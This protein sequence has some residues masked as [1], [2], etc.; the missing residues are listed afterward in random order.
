MAWTLRYNDALQS[1]EVTF[2][3]HVGGPEVHES[4]SEAIA[5]LKKH[6]AMRALVD[7]TEMESAPPVVDI[8]D[9]PAKQYILEDLSYDVLIALI[10]PNTSKIKEAARFYETVCVNRGWNVQSFPNRGDAIEW[11]TR[12]SAVNKEDNTR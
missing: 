3:G 4:T 12:K 6:G 9:L 5:L 2:W 7:T 10:V 1:I 11:L 8:Y